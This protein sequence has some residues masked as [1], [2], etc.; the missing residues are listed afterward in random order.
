V[1]VVTERAGLAGGRVERAAGPWRTSGEW[2]QLSDARCSAAA[3]RCRW[4][5]TATVGRG[6]RHGGIYRVYR[7]RDRNR[8][9][10]DGIV[11]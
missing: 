3:G 2:W 11:D 8:W 7:G 10:V 1:R 5:G 9:F 4:A 6:A